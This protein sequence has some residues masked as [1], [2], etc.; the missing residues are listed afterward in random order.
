VSALTAS[1]A[2]FNV[3]ADLVLIAQG[4]FPRRTL[5]AAKDEADTSADLSLSRSSSL[6][7][8]QHRR[9]KAVET[10]RHAGLFALCIAL[11]LVVWGVVVVR[12]RSSGTAD[13]LTPRLSL[14]FDP[15]VPGYTFGWAALAILRASTRFS[16]RHGT[17]HARTQ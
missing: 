8:A 17:E 11:A 14:P 3:L 1:Q 2:A 13:I 6:A 15:F 9:A 16:D 4:L 12:V 7:L 5:P 10:Y